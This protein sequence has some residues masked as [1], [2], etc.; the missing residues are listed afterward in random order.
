MVMAQPDVSA[1]IIAGP[2]M[3]VRMAFA[4]EKTMSVMTATMVPMA[5]TVG[6]AKKAVRVS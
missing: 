5:A 4:G 1:M 2:S 6:M 3:C